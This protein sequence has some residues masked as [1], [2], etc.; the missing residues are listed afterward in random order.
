M[1][2]ITQSTQAQDVRLHVSQLQ[3]YWEHLILSLTT[4]IVSVLS[5]DLSHSLDENS[6][7]MK[8]KIN[9]LLN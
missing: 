5:G 2:T 7:E 9:D 1:S 6:S 8:K 3:D 4:L